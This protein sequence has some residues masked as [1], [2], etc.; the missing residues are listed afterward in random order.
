MVDDLRRIKSP[1]LWHEVYA[2]MVRHSAVVSIKRR[3]WGPNAPARLPY[4]DLGRA[5]TIY[6][7]QLE[8]DNRYFQSAEEAARATN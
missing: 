4:S 2:G 3:F 5:G 8:L 7:K 1:Q 6:E